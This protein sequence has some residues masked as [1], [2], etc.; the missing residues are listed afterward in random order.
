MKSTIVLP[1][2][3]ISMLLI[4]CTDGDMSGKA[5]DIL[6]QSDYQFVM[7]DLSGHADS[8]DVIKVIS[9]INYEYGLTT[10][11]PSEMSDGQYIFITYSDSP[12]IIYLPENYQPAETGVKID[13]FS[14]S[15]YMTGIDT[16]SLVVGLDYAAENFEDFMVDKCVEIIDNMVTDCTQ[17][18][19]E[20]NLFVSIATLKDNYITGEHIK[21]TDPPTKTVGMHPEFKLLNAYAM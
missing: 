5:F 12:D 7:T 4:S 16:T 21:I 1:I 6:A 18:G 17:Q 9:G 10:V 14:G 15:I 20:T 13:S 19:N 11:F 3:L 2:L 8:G